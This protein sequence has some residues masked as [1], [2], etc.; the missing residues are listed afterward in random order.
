MNKT[1]RNLVR[2]GR[3]EDIDEIATIAIQCFPGDFA[4]GTSGEPDIAIAA[5]WVAHRMRLGDYGKYIVLEAERCVLGYVFYLLVAGVGGVLQ[6][7]QIAIEQGYRRKGLG[8]KLIL[9][10]EKIM[11]EHLLRRFGC[12]LRKVYLTTSAENHA[13]HRLYAKAHYARYATVT[14]LLWDVDEEIWV[15]DVAQS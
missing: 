13:A 11:R 10:S 1:P 6:L 2:L 8:I 15:K 7:E 9:T 4:N 3:E 5:E 12:K 14:K